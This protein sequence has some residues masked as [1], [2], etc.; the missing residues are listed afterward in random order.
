MKWII[1]LL[2]V[3]FDSFK[4]TKKPDPIIIETTP[5][6][7]K[8]AEPKLPSP[9]RK[10][11]IARGHGGADSGCQNSEITELEYNTWVMNELEKAGLNISCHYGSNSA[12]S[13]L[14]AIASMPDLIIQMHVNDADNLSANGCEV[15]VVD[16]DTRS[17]VFAEEFAEN[18][19][20]EFNKPTRRVSTKGKKILDSNDRGVKSLKLSKLCPKILVEPFFIKNKTDFIPKEK[21]LEFM[22]KQLK[23]WG[24]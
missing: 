15:L 7:Q 13:M 20:K 1:N 22:I 24:A 16:G 4:E 17:Y 23:S 19:N 12:S 9:K 5:P 2:K 21:Y 3:L 18:L 11:A 6:I 14:K 10:I 8:P